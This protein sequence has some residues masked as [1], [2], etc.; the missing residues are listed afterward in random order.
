MLQPWVHDFLWAQ[1]VDNKKSKYKNTFGFKKFRIYAL[2][3][4]YGSVRGYGAQLM[5]LA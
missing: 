1:N 5:T 2:G 3:Y 4:G